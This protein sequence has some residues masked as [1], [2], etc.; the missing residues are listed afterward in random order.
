MHLPTQA[1]PLTSQA[2]SLA[3]KVPEITAMFWVIKVL[4]TGMGEALS[5]F[6]I[7]HGM[8]LGGMLGAGIYIF[9]SFVAFAITMRFQL[10]TRRYHAYAY[11]F[12]VSMVAVF[13]TAAADALFGGLDLSFD[14]TSALFAALTV[15]LFVVW[16]RSEGTL[17]VHSIV[18][19]RPERFYWATVLATFALGTAVGDLT[20]VTFDLGFLLSGILFLAAILIPLAAWR[21]GVNSVAAFWAAYVLTRPLGASFAD[22]LAK[23]DAGLG[24]GD[25]WV[26]LVSL[27]AIVVLVVYVAKREAHVEVQP[28]EAIAAEA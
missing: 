27:A 3:V 14:V 17:S 18:A 20:A 22:W 4:T 11:W 9:L 7:Q 13:G 5:D 19:G 2:G 21:L 6:F 16:Y 10:R 23:E 26:A 1:R 24:Y 28:E 25:G 8:A 12:G 15:I